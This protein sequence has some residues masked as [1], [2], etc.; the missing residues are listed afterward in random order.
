MSLQT[1]AEREFLPLT[2]SLAST[3]RWR[4]QDYEAM[5]RAEVDL[6]LSGYDDEDVHADREEA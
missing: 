6:M 3:I 1:H 4:Y 2:D 5:L